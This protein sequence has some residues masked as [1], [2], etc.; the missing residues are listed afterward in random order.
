LERVGEAGEAS[1]ADERLHALFT[2][3]GKEHL[4]VSQVPAGDIGALVIPS[5]ASILASSEKSEEAQELISFLLTERSQAYF[6]DETY[7]YP[8]ARNVPAAEGVP[9]LS[10]LR[11][12][13][14]DPGR[15]ADIEGTARLISESGLN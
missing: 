10:S 12:P 4:T 8:L 6:A 2:L 1:G 3:Q 5:S 13:D 15:L 7:E 9:P 11:P 14:E